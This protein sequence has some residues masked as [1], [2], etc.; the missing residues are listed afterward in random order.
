LKREGELP[1]LGDAAIWFFRETN[2]DSKQIVATGN[3]KELREGL[4][5][6]LYQTGSKR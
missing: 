1:S 3:G 4:E 2:L 5:N 6:V